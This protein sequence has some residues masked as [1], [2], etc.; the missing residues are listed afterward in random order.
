M[1]KIIYLLIVILTVA[2]LFVS[3][4]AQ[5]GTGGSDTENGG[6]N[7]TPG[8]SQSGS[9]NVGG[10]SDSNGENGGNISDSVSVTV[11]VIVKG[12]GLSVSE[13]IFTVT[14]GDRLEIPIVFDNGYTFK[15]ASIPGEFDY[16]RGVFVIESIPLS[17]SRIELEAKT[18]E[19]YDF[20][21]YLTSGDTVSISDGSYAEGMVV[22]ATAGSTEGTFIGWSFGSAYSDGGKIVSGDKSFSFKLGVD[23]TSNSGAV[24]L[25]ANYTT[26]NVYYYDLNGGAVNVNSTNMKDTSYYTASV[27]GDRV[28]V[29][30]G[31]KYFEVVETASTFYDDATFTREGYVLVEYNTKPDGTGEGFNTGAKFQIDSVEG[32][33]VLYCIWEKEADHQS[34]TFREVNNN[35]PGSSVTV[36]YWQTSG[37]QIIE[38]TGNEKIVAIPNKIG[39]KYV[40]SIDTGAFKNKDVETVI[41]GRYILEVKDGAF[42][43]CD[44]LKTIY[45]SDGI[46]YATDNFLDANSTKSFKNLRINAVMPPKRTNDQWAGRFAIKLTRVMS[47]A[48]TRRVIMFGGSSVYEG[49]S[50]TYME[51]L[52]NNTEGED[53]SFI[54]FGIVRH[55]TIM[56]YIDAIEHYTKE[57]DVVIMSPENHVRALGDTTFDANSIGCAEGMYP[58]LMRY[59]DAS[60][61]SRI[62]TSLSEFNRNRVG[63]APTRYEELCRVENGRSAGHNRYGDQ[64]A[65]YNRRSIMRNQAGCVSY[66][67]TYMITFNDKIKTNAAP[68]W[69]NENE[70]TQDWRNPDNDTWCSLTEPQYA[71]QVN[72]II[73]EVKA[74]GAMACF[75]YAP[76]DGTGIQG[77]TFG[78]IPEV[79]AD[80]ENW[81]S[82]YDNLIKATYY[83]YDAYVGCSANYIFHH[84]YFF[85]SAYHLNNYGRA[86]WTYQFYTD[87]CGIIGIDDP[88]GYLDCGTSFEGCMFEPG[89]SD[90]KPTYTVDYIEEMKN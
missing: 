84:N 29:V 61:Y 16:S 48:D 18:I 26:K 74:S 75:S 46:T 47:T 39:D 83:E 23:V 42:V 64:L 85:D 40:I 69:Q 41:F 49:M 88:S 19:R 28:Q 24:S 66:T 4:D 30:L 32:I 89:V 44:S 36:P 76:V 52:L 79:K 6:T 72:R 31:A 8:G 45:Y 81:L 9:G 22:N 65:D 34:F 71:D 35:C 38:Y 10:S 43:N 87:L 90:G 86:I 7:D 3:C 78:V 62:F 37:L 15:S 1:K 58:S 53:Y 70:W 12:S 25:Y 82:A 60:Q 13:S 57:G 20:R 54:N 50:S 80:A 21:S 5:S 27:N 73:S 59:L 68:N 77:S 11:R 63:Q 17:V 14:E 2:A 67:D 51:A 55:Y 33:P 56:P